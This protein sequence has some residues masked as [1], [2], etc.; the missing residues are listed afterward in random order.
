MKKPLSIIPLNNIRALIHTFRGEQV[1][2][3]SDLAEIYGVETKVFNQ[4]VKRN[5]ERFP[6]T[7]RFQLTE[8]EYGS[9]KTRLEGSSSDAGLRSQNAT[10][11]ESENL[12][13]QNATSRAAGALRSQIVTSSHGG[14]R[15]LPYAFTEQGVSMLSAV[16]RSETA[17][18]VSIQIIHAFVEMRRFLQANASIFARM[19]S[20][21]KRQFALESKTMENFEKVFRA[22]EAAEPPKQGIFYEGQVHDAHAFASDL[23]R[24]AKS[25]ITLVDNYVD[26]TVLT[27]LT[28][29]KKSVAATIFTK[30]ISRQLALDLAKHNAQYPPIE[31]KTFQAAHDRFLILDERDIYHIGASLK[32]LGKKWFAFS[33]FESGALDMLKKLGGEQ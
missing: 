23:I 8:E 18:K 15:Y 31:I 33:K 29:R 22:L 9:L 26:D 30:N 5:I 17:V 27:L 11:E 32:D 14:R 13:S 2:L 28:K 6:E 19:D 4:A 10:L 7:F 24:K 21:E 1:M 3:D 16:L 20:M 25:S 12:R